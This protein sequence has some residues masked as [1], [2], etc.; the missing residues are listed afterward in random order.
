MTDLQLLEQYA[1]TRDAEAFADLVKRYAGMVYATCLRIT[2][3]AHAAEDASQECFLQLARQAGTVRRSLAGWL[4]KTATSRALMIRRGDASRRDR[5]RK[6]VQMNGAKAQGGDPT[7]AEIAPCVDEALSELPDDLRDLLARHFLQGRTQAEVAE[8]IGVDRSTVSRRLEKGLDRLRAMLKR[9]GVI[10]TSALLGTL[11]GSKAAQAAPIAL[12]AAL[13]KMA[14]AGISA[15]G[16]TV[17]A[18]AATSLI[19]GGAVMSKVAVGSAVALGIGVVLVASMVVYRGHGSEQSEVSNS[20]RSPADSL[21]PLLKVPEDEVAPFQYDVA[22]V[23]VT[24][25]T[26]DEFA[27]ALSAELEPIGWK[28]EIPILATMSEGLPITTKQGQDEAIWLAGDSLMVFGKP[29]LQIEV[30]KFLARHRA[31]AESQS[32]AATNDTDLEA[33]LDQRFASLQLPGCTLAEVLTILQTVMEHDCKFVID[34]GWDSDN[35]LITLDVQN[36]TLREVLNLCLKPNGADFAIRN[37]TIFISSPPRL[38]RLTADSIP[39]AAGVSL[40]GGGEPPS[41]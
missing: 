25:G 39:A 18:T 9:R 26:M 35:L 11:L 21:G 10:V 7:W 3:N 33:V 24:L 2:G 38:Q 19:T 34:P 40:R 17:A 1:A 12:T 4:Q 23:I 37:G 13:G 41:R 31:T 5:E 28:G 29:K 15:E 27:K 6:A 22:D 36:V 8:E 14:M 20:P 30:S 32:A 16:K